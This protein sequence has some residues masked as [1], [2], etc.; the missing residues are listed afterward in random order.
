[1]AVPA[2][3]QWIKDRALQLWH[4]PRGGKKRKRKKGKI[5]LPR[6]QPR[7]TNQNPQG[8]AQLSAFEQATPWVLLRCQDGA[9]PLPPQHCGRLRGASLWP[10]PGSG[11]QRSLVCRKAAV[12]RRFSSLRS[13]VHSFQMREFGS[14][15]GAGSFRTRAVPACTVPPSL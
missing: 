4:V 5:L 11:G 1:M 2:V 10:W 13:L 15:T 8:G 7:P 14:P 6:P 3:A 12:S 9:L